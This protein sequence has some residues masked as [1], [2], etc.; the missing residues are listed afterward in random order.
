MPLQL[1]WLP[2]GKIV[3]PC[4][5]YVKFVLF[6]VTVGQCGVHTVPTRVYPNIQL[7]H[8]VG[9]FKLQV[10]QGAWHDNWHRFE[11]DVEL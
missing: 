10:K 3:I 11:L 2:P 6:T 9:L 5:Q 8:D 7:V 4:P 1:V